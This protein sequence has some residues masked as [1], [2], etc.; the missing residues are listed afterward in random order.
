ML[1]EEEVYNGTKR[2]L[3]KNNFV[4]LAGQPPR[5]VDH[6]PVVE[7]KSG[8]NQEKG[9]KDAFKPD[10]VAFKDNL[11]FI[12]ECKPRFNNGDYQKLN[13]ILNCNSRL[14]AFFNE[15]VQRKIIQKL[16][17][18]LEFEQ[19]RNMI[20]GSLAYGIDLNTNS[21]YFISESSENYNATPAIDN[22]FQIIVYDWKGTGFLVHPK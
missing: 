4:L 22:I 16:N 20:V 3:L 8:V 6:L 17:I 1:S 15:L 11:F 18:N 2:F 21:N 19:F 9:S 7:I 13:K 5:G 12:I 14:Y 10:L